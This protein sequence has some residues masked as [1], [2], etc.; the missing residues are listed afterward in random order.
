MTTHVALGGLLSLAAAV[1]SHALGGTADSVVR[2]NSD[3][4]PGLSLHYKWNASF[5]K[6]TIFIPVRAGLVLR[7]CSLVRSRACRTRGAPQFP[8]PS[9]LRRR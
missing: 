5:S 8:S 6:L 3:L 1:G 9:T 7:R 4:Y 2:I